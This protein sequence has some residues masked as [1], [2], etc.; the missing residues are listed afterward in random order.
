MIVFISLVVRGFINNSEH[1][2]GHFRSE[3]EELQVR[4]S[5]ERE[6]YQYMASS[7]NRVSAVPQVYK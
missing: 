4:I 3:I 2:Y 5:R 6:N 7:D 1:C